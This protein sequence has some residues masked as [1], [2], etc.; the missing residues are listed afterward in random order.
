MNE[1]KPDYWYRQSAVVPYRRREGQLEVL[2]ITSSKKKR[3][4]IPKGIVEPGLSPAASAAQEA[5]EE[6]G[7]IGEVSRQPFTSYEQQK[8][9]GICHVEVFLLKVTETLACW[10]EGQRRDRIWVTLP[11]ARRLVD[12]EGLQAV[13]RQF[14]EVLRE[15]TES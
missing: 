10:P 14:P 9:G 13:L 3:W 7:V 1:T 12:R 15:Y 6:A 11:E 8:W 2:L 4:I 5:L